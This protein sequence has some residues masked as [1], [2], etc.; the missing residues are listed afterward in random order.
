[1]TTKSAKKRKR[2]PGKEPFSSPYTDDER[3]ALEAPSLVGELERAIRKS[4]SAREQIER[5]RHL[6]FVK[7]DESD[8]SAVLTAGVVLR[9]VSRKLFVTDKLR[10]GQRISGKNRG[11]ELRRAAQPKHESICKLATKLLESGTG[12]REIV[13][14][15]V[16]AGYPET[17]ARR[18]LKKHP[19]GHWAS[20]SIK[21]AA[22]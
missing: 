14:S 17:T 6:P 1:M 7:P 11:E 21:S 5:G 20:K 10:A 9:E 8:A 16:E 12:P 18:A 2:D 4:Q 22:S 19:S 3:M 15:I 13:S